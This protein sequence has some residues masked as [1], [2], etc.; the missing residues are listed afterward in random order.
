MKN[1]KM[2]GGIIIVL[3]LTMINLNSLVSV[4]QDFRISFESLVQ[5][6]YANGELTPCDQGCASYEYCDGTYCRPYVDNFQRSC[7]IESYCGYMGG[8]YCGWQTCAGSKTT[9]EPD[10]WSN[11]VS[12]DSPST[13]C[14]GCDPCYENCW[15]W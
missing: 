7:T 10:I 6:V 1:Y 14:D 12:C 15:G 11:D 9:C 8:S 13:V 2:I 5:Q 4:S 3:I